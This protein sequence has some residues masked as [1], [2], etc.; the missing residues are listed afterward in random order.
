MKKVIIPGTFDPITKG[1]IYLIKEACKLAERVLV[2]VVENAD[3]KT[4]FS[5]EE[6]KNFVKEACRNMPKVEVC[7]FSGLVIDLA[8]REGAEAVVRGIRNGSDFDYEFGLAQIYN[9]TGNGLKSIFIPA[10]DE[11]S[12][13]SSSMVRELLRHGK[14]ATEYIPFE[15]KN[16]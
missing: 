6:R 2:A 12:F 16:N 8:K 7:S 3:K 14:S 9:S 13:V 1:H 15:L 10:L 5:S 4:M 11:Y